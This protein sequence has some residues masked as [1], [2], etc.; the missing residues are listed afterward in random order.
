MCVGHHLAGA[1]GDQSAIGGKGQQ[2]LEFGAQR[3]IARAARFE[4]RR[5]LRLGQLQE[6]IKDALDLRKG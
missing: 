6:F 1:A 4:E 2:R 5:S 3:V